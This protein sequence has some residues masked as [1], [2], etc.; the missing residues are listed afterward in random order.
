RR[1]LEGPVLEVRAAEK[2]FFPGTPRRVHALDCVDLTVAEGSLVV[3][4]G[5]NGSGKSTLLNAVAGTVLLDFRSIRI[6]AP[7]VPRWP[8]HRRASLIGR[9]FQDPFKGTAPSMSIAENL[10][11]AARRG[12]P[13]RL[14]WGL[15]RQ[16]R[17]EI[18]E[19]VN[20]FGMGLENMLD[21]PI[22]T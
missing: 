20:M 11:L 9:V 2:T 17:K 7:D 18:Q 22:G 13:R 21:N 10:A 14:G 15:P 12:R 4:I 3:V 1:A 5:T 8:E 6:A 19:T 16:V